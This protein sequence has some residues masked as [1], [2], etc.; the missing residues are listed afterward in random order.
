MTL[1]CALLFVIALIKSHF[2]PDF[3]ILSSLVGGVVMA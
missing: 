2:S 3:V 1:I